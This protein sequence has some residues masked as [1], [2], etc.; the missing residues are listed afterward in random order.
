MTRTYSHDRSKFHRVLK[1]F[2][3]LNMPGLRIRSGCDFVLLLLFF[4]FFYSRIFTKSV[5]N[6][7]SPGNYINFHTWEIKQK[8]K[9]RVKCFVNKNWYIKQK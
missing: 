1:I 7:Q 5:Q 3:I 9:T 4:V 2:P 6:L 8:L